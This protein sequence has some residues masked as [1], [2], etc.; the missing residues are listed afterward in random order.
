MIGSK[1]LERAY[2][3]TNKKESTF[4]DGNT[5]TF[6]EELNYA[7]GKRVLDI[8]RANVDKNATMQNAYADLRST[9]GLVAGDDGFNG[10]YAF[11]TDLIKPVRV[12]VKFKNEAQPKK[13]TF[14]DNA[15]NRASEFSDESINSVFSQSSPM[16]DF[17]RNSYKIR[18]LNSTVGD[19]TN[20]IYIEY[21]KRQSDF[22]SSTEPTDIEENLQ[23][24]LAFDLAT[25]EHIMHSKKYDPIEF[26]S[27]RAEKQSVENR[28]NEFYRFRL[29]VKKVMTFNHVDYS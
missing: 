22:T 29:P 11:P 13:C 4:L 5:T 16:V 2:R 12:E 27:F 1:I 19:V 23:D 9:V 8:L 7:Y 15:M 6:Y 18:P 25:Q 10:E 26:Q 24:I 17:F 28:F 21:E 20:G 14:Y 3:L